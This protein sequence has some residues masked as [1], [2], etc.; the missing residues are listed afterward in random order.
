M[1]ERRIQQQVEARDRAT[2]ASLTD[3]AEWL[4][5]IAV[6]AD[7]RAGIEFDEARYADDLGEMVWR[8]LGMDADPTTLVDALIHAVRA[9][10]RDGERIPYP[11]L[12]A[13][14]ALRARVIEHRAETIAWQMENGK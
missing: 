12:D 7:R 6:E 14:V 3:R 8:E 13:Y 5:D 4:E 11:I 9:C 10:K 2:L 1:D